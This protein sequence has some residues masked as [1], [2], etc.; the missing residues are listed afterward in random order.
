[1]S[2]CDIHIRYD[3]LDYRYMAFD[4]RGIRL[5]PECV[6]AGSCVMAKRMLNWVDGVRK[7][8]LEQPLT[9]N[10][11]LLLLRAYRPRLIRHCERLLS[12]VNHI[13]LCT[14]KSGTVR[15]ADLG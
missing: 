10:H 2:M 7:Q 6:N 12:H 3:P 14:I 8:M 9:L 5:S 1:M 15:N 4:P 13:R 11:Q